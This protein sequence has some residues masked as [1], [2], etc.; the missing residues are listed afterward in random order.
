MEIYGATFANRV[1]R[2]PEARREARRKRGLARQVQRK[3]QKEQAAKKLELRR[4]SSSTQPVT[5]ILINGIV[6]LDQKGSVAKPV[7]AFLS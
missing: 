1:N 7:T 4:S 6:L 5:A 3:A 2:N